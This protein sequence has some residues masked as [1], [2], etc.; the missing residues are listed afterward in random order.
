M[1]AARG[2][3]LRSR[4]KSRRHARQTVTKFPRHTYWTMGPWRVRLWRLCLLHRTGFDE[5]EAVSTRQSGIALRIPCINS[6]WKAKVRLREK[7]LHFR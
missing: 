7:A 4:S 2:P 5:A 3:K 6:F 1:L